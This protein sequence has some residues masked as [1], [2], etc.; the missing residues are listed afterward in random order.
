MVTFS[1][2]AFRFSVAVSLALTSPAA[3]QGYSA[4]GSNPLLDTIGESPIYPIGDAIPVYRA[5]LDLLY[6]NGGERPTTIMMHDS[7]EGR[8]EGPCALELCGHAWPHKSKID[9][10]TILAFTGL[11]RKR[12]AI[13]DFGY[14]IPIVFLSNDD[15]Q[16]MRADGGEYVKAHPPSGFGIEPYWVEF[17]REHPGA[18]GETMLTKVG[19]NPGHTQALVQVRHQCGGQ[20]YSN[21]IL[22]L[23]QTNRRWSVVERIPNG[24]GQDQSTG[25]LRYIGPAG[26]IPEESELVAHNDSGNISEAT[27][28]AEVYR[29][30]IDSL[31]SFYGEKPRTIVLTDRFQV[32]SRALPAH[33]NLVDTIVVQK[34]A[35]LGM[36]RSP[37]DVALESRIPIVRLSRDSLPELEKRGE[38][39]DPNHYVGRPFWLAFLERYPGAWGMLGL[40]RIAFNAQRTE[41]LVYA[42][43]TCGSSC[44]NGDTWFL[45]RTGGRWR[46]A[47]RMPRIRN[48]ELDLE[49]LRY[50]GLDAD[51]NAYRPRRVRGTVTD[52]VTH[53]RLP[54]LKMRVRRNFVYAPVIRTESIVRTDSRG[55]FSLTDLPLAGGVEMMVGCPDQSHHDSLNVA[56]ILVVPGLDTAVNVPIDFRKCIR[57]SPVVPRNILSG[58]QAFIGPTEARFVFPRQSLSLY[59]WDVPSKGPRPRGEGYMWDVTWEIP[60]SSDGKYPITLW[61]LKPWGSGGLRIGSLKDLIT[62]LKLEPMI[63]CV[64]CDGAVFED[65]GTDH[66]NVFATV[67]DGSLVFVVRGA[68]AVRR[69]FPTIPATVRFHATIRDS[70]ENDY[71]PSATHQG[72]AVIVNCRNS[73]VSRAARQRCD[74]RK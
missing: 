31:Y 20:C 70:P 65:P 9:T 33:K 43:H 23:E 51:R 17:D 8:S 5:V 12:P 2:N 38:A 71:G 29:L 36:L 32:A 44:E 72:Q 68:E 13:R 11:S 41:A 14:S 7:V 25:S 58:A 54:F 47:E 48:T 63:N 39:L 19:F 21:E 60:D 69:I 55:R 49:G 4:A 35:Y 30:V 28:R 10:A 64:T 6:K 53:R 24:A 37:L 73:N 27:D 26:G 66:N 15:V 45:Q 74:A 59:V 46:I 50:L 52:A 56:S 34:Y 57:E 22:F 42:D 1:A 62:G 16:R 61:L 40:S 67:E 3:A 18:W